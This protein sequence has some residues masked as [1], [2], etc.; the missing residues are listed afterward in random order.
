M[1]AAQFKAGVFCWKDLLFR[2]AMRLLNNTAEAEDAVQQTM[3]KLW[4]KKEEL[5]HIENLRAFVIK[6]LKN[7]CLNRLKKQQ[8]V[9]M[10]HGQYGKLQSLSSELVQGNMIE[11]IKE[12][13]NKLPE[14][15]KLIIQLCDVEGFEHKEIAAILEIEEGAV[16]TNLSRARQKIK[17]QIIKLQTYEERKL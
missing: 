4:Q 13:I 6:V 15:Q 3:M 7:D 12:E 2:L 11:I 16:R 10:H 9:S 8:I 14:K 5:Q 1:D 17:T